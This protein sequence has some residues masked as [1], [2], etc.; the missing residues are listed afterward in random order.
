MCVE[1]MNSSARFVRS[2]ALGEKG[3]II[4]LCQRVQ[5]RISSDFIRYYFN[6]LLPGLFKRIYVVSASTRHV[7][8][9]GKLPSVRACACVYAVSFS[10]HN[11]PPP[12]F[13]FPQVDSCR[14]FPDILDLLKS[15]IILTECSFGDR[16]RW[17][18][19]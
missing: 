11:M 18:L 5:K 2:A 7:I 3:G 9:N 19:E 4:G 12:P 8:T 1:K 6:L 16:W 14:Y 17:R 10:I 15:S 13:I